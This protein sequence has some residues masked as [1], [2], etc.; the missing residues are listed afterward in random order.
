MKHW[1]ETITE[2]REQRFNRLLNIGKRIVVDGDE[3]GLARQKK[4]AMHQAS[5]LDSRFHQQTRNPV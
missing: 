3:V 5:L 4:I 1:T 2:T